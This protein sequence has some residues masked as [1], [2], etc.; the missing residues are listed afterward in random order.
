MKKTLLTLLSAVLLITIVQPA[1]AAVVKPCS[2]NKLNTIQNNLICKKVGLLYRWAAIPTPINTNKPVAPTPTPTSTATPTPTPTSSPV[3]VIDYKETTYKKIINVY[4]SKTDASFEL[5]VISDSS[6]LDTS[7]K[8][9]I[10]RYEI[11]TKF[12][13]SEIS[14]KK[15]LIIIG[16]ND[17]IRWIKEQ[18]ELAFPYKYDDWYVRNSQNMPSEKCNSYSAGSYGANSQ[19]YLV[20]SFRLY[21][22]SCPTQEPKDENYR[23]TVEHEFTH[24]AQSSLTNNYVESLPCWFREGQATYYGSVMGNTL[25]YEDFLKSRNYALFNFT[26]N[27]FKDTLIKLDE[28]YSN[29]NCGTDGGF[30]YGSIAIE[31]LLKLYSHDQI[32]LFVKS[33]GITRNWKQS[34]ADT[35]NRKFEDWAKFPEDSILNK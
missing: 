32:N 1:Q 14:Q 18:L 8:N 10:R 21:A 12:W 11:A 23:T 4:N 34:F 35:F 6:V 13:G 2:K 30:S 16:S 27:N 9:I 28:K 25:S 24:A 26:T 3:P 20:Q 7:V 22:P 19:G 33:A 31:Q 29:F 15:L 5:K 17:N